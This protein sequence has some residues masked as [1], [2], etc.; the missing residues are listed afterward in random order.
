MHLSLFVPV[1]GFLAVAP[2]KVLRVLSLLFSNGLAGH[3]S[4]QLVGGSLVGSS[5]RMVEVIGPVGEAK[6][7]LHQVM[8][9]EQQDYE[10]SGFQLLLQVRADYLL[11]GV[12]LHAI[13][14]LYRA[15]I[16]PK[17]GVIGKFALHVG[18]EQ[19]EAPAETI[20]DKQ[21][22]WAALV[23]LRRVEGQLPVGEGRGFVLRYQV[24]EPVEVVVGSLQ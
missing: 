18:A 8:L 13:G 10:F 5:Q 12:V 14:L 6:F 2:G 16:I 4:G 19:H 23:G 20:V 21:R 22:R 24:E 9:R 3:F 7:V 11:A 17:V 1:A 15:V